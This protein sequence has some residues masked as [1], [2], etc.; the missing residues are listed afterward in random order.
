MPIRCSPFESPP[1]PVRWDSPGPPA[2][3]LGAC[4]GPDGGGSSP[5]QLDSAPS[6]TLAAG[7]TRPLPRVGEG[8]L[9]D[10]VTRRADVTPPRATAWKVAPRVGPVVEPVAAEPRRARPG[11]HTGTKRK[12]PLRGFCVWLPDA[13]GFAN[14]L[15]LAT[16][17]RSWASR[18]RTPPWTGVVRPTKGGWRVCRRRIPVAGVAFGRPQN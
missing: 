6:M 15:Y 12:K 9:S 2:W 11:A 4:G 17:A 16:A 3:G 8:E 1:G 18:S 14:V 13:D 7:Q 10:R 5:A